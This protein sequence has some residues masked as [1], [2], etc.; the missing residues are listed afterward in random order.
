[1]PAMNARDTD[2]MKVLNELI[3][4]EASP[5]YPLNKGPQ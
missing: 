3:A 5:R 2:L 1:M 4:H